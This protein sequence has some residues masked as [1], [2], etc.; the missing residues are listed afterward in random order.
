MKKY[1][2]ILISTF[3]FSQNNNYKVTYEFNR[4]VGNLKFDA[5]GVLEMDVT[6]SVSKFRLS[7]YQNLLK[8]GKKIFDTDRNDSIVILGSSSICTENKIYFYDFKKDSLTSIL[9]NVNCKSKVI[10][11]DKIVNPKWKIFNEYKTISG[12]KSQKA[13]AFINDRTWTVYFTNKFNL[14]FAPWRLIGLPG[15]ILEATENYN[16][17]NFKFVKLEKLVDTEK[18]TKPKFNIK[19]SF[20]EFV[21]KSVKQQKDEM[22]F[23]LSQMDGIKIED[24]D[25]NS[26]P[27]YE[28][29]DFVEKK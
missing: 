2:I 1:I 18:I 13:T 5:L 22:I 16:I 7:Q 24:I 6:N 3:C 29:L 28:T 9:Y 27:P 14:N 12:Y 15:A 26:F 20:E 10:I 11:E 4:K 23:K 19:S 17:Y 25:V 8:N 21:K